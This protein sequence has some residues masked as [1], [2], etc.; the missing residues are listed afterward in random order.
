VFYEDEA[1][2]GRHSNER[3]CW[4]SKED[5]PKVKSQ[6]VRESMYAFS[7]LC[8]SSGD[9]YSITSPYCNTEAMNALLL[10]M[11]IRYFN[12]KLIIIMDKAAW[13][14]SQGIELPENIQI[15]HLPPYSPQL[16]PVEIFWREIRRNHFDN[17]LF[18]NMDD[19]EKTLLKVL[20]QYH[21][22][23]DAI[24]KLSKGYNLY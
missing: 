13:H 7:A 17:E 15:L 23:P 24:I 8:P 2:F 9:C 20:K 6:F 21:K 11:S 10:A 12:N 3:Y 16:N 18:E 19:V 5:T 1:R 14:I 4:V 22:K